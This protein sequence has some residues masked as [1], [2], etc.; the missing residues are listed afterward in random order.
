MI[1]FP[2]SL[3][4]RITWVYLLIS[5]VT[6][7]II[8]AVL[9]VGIS[10][11]VLNDSIESSN[12]AVLKSSTLVGMYIERLKVSS[13]LL[14]NNPQTIKTLSSS[15]KEGEEDELQFIRA[16]LKSDANIKSVVVIGKD[17]Y[18]LSNESQLNMQ[19]SSDMMDEQWYVDAIN[20]TYPALTSARMQK[21]T[22]DKDKW[23]IS[24]SEEVKDGNN[25][26]LGVVLLDIEYKGIES[27]L[28]DLNL[29]SK[30]FAFIMNSKGEIVYHKDT[31]Y[32]VDP[33]KQAELRKISQ[34]KEGYDGKHNVLLYKTQL[35]NTDWTLVGVSSLDGFAANSQPAA[36]FIRN[37]EPRAAAAYYYDLP[38]HCQEHYTTDSSLGTGDGEGED[39]HSG[40]ERA[41]I[42]SDRGA[43]ACPA[44]QHDGVGDEGP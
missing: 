11:V 17:G 3:Q 33:V 6:L 21:F 26:N 36:S 37:C 8:G 2:R 30:G 14:A 20:N 28:N 7:G 25:R 31:A 40:S 10:K 39:R 15:T 27:Y 34:A 4:A 38:F 29:G 18:V 1:R 35:K 19:R 16:V 9:Y 13:T 22:M 24:M 23:V 42:G 32:F 43:R 41:G 5:V 44:F 12:M